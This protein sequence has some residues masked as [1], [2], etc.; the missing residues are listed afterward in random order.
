MLVLKKLIKLFVY[1]INK[2]TSTTLLLLLFSFPKKSHFWALFLL[3]E[4][5]FLISHIDYFSIKNNND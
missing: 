1:I 2:K 5:V 4:S 3:S